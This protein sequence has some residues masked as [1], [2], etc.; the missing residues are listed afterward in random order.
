M[1]LDTG[2]VVFVGEGS[3]WGRGRQG[4]LMRRTMT[5]ASGRRW[6]AVEGGLECAIIKGI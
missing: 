3:T 6:S 1:D 5:T 4:Q 2:A